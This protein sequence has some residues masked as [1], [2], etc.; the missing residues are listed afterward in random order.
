MIDEYALYI[1]S[2]Y[3]Y[4]DKTDMYDHKVISPDKIKMLLAQKILVRML[5]LIKIETF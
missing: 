2:T 5:F 4:K 3:V 1:T